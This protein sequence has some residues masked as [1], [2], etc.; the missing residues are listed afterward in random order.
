VKIAIHGADRPRPEQLGSLS[1]A[2]PSRRRLASRAELRLELD[3]TLLG[4][5]E[6]V[7]SLGVGGDAQAGVAF[8][9]RD[10]EVD[11][12]GPAR[13]PV[14]LYLSLHEITVHAVPDA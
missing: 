9:R 2:R 3:H 1:A 10:D 4:R 13:R 6:Q 12:E 7:T 5:K 14:P 11:G 8:D